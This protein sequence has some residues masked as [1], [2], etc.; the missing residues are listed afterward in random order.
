[1]GHATT[2]IGFYRNPVVA[3][4]SYAHRNLLASRVTVDHGIKAK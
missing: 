2:L 3:L 1:M 4:Y